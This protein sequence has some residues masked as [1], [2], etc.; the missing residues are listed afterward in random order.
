MHTYLGLTNGGRL[1]DRLGDLLEI[2]GGLYEGLHADPAHGGHGGHGGHGDHEDHREVMAQEADYAES[3]DFGDDHRSIGAGG[4]HFLAGC[5]DLGNVG[6]SVGTGLDTEMGGRDTGRVEGIRTGWQA[7]TG[8][9][10]L[11]QVGCVGREVRRDYMGLEGPCNLGGLWALEGH[12]GDREGVGEDVHGDL[13]YRRGKMLDERMDPVA[14]RDDA[15]GGDVEEGLVVGEGVLGSV[16]GEAGQGKVT[17]RTRC[18]S[19]LRRMGCEEG[20]VVCYA[21][22]GLLGN[23]SG[24]EQLASAQGS[25]VRG[26]AA[27][28]H[29]HRV[30]AWP[31]TG[32][33]LVGLDGHPG[34][35][36]VDERPSP[37]ALFPPSRCRDRTRRNTR[38]GC[39]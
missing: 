14:K 15:G 19:G 17:R 37:R 21:V 1:E 32:V 29:L 18:L 22:C 26:G 38:A 36:C 25:R 20:V 16:P 8:P 30:W 10:H 39:G 5:E 24:S 4:L 33:L 28:G 7:E 2:H 13:G 12:L 34:S 23:V 11:G 6:S 27:E 9:K 3:R 35:L 31:V